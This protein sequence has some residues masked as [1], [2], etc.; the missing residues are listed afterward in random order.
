MRQ[1]DDTEPH[2]HSSSTEHVGSQLQLYGWRPIVDELDPRPMPEDYV[3]AGAVT[4]IFDALVSSLA[5][6]ALDPDLDE[7]LWS[8]VNMFHRAAARLE[9]QLDDNERGQRRSQQEQDGTEVKS[10]ELERLHAMGQVLIDR[11]DAIELMRDQAAERY[12]H[13]T[14]SV[15]R[16]RTGSM[17]NRSTLTAALVDS[18]DFINARHRAEVEV[19]VP[20][21][22]KIALSGGMDFNDHQLVWDVLDKVHAKHPEMVLVHGKSP[23]G[24]EFIAAKWADTR[25]VSQIGFAPD[26]ARD[27]KAAPFKRNDAM[28]DVLPTGIIIFPGTGIQDNLA[29][30]ARKLGIKVFDCRNRGGA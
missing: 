7:L 27:G 1:H 29:D 16:P 28:L 4:D 23:K 21:G 9:R 2:H 11:R 13:Q 12:E 26:W 25:K 19:M 8:T 17:V 22:P 5:D 6:T 15:W 20:P 30:K 10:V 14:G 18:R 24:A 3:I